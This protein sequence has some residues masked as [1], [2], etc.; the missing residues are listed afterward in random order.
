M[1]FNGVMAHDTHV[2]LVDRS[3]MATDMHD[4]AHSCIVVCVKPIRCCI[5]TVIDIPTSDD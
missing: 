2:W 4:V 5:I 3:Y 1:L